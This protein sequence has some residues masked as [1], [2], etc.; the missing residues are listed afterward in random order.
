MRSFAIALAATAA[1]PMPGFAQEVVRE[2]DAVEDNDEAREIIVTGSRFGGRT[3]TQ[4]STPVDAISREA[5]QQSGR[6]D[7]IQMLKV[8]VPS[9]SAPRPMPL[10]ELRSAVVWRRLPLIRTS[11]SPAPSPRREGGWMKSP[12]PDASGRGALKLGT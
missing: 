9:F 10:L 2:A 7:L 5:L 11:S 6:V 4:S 12:T 3:A 8:Q 1:M